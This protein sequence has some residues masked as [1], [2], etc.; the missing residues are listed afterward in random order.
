LI[1]H[2]ISTKNAFPKTNRN[3]TGKIT[4]Q[5]EVLMSYPEAIQE[6]IFTTI[7]IFYIVDCSGCKSMMKEEWKETIR[8]TEKKFVMIQQNIFS[9]LLDK[10]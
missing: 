10:R 3:S 5:H 6:Q 9:F 7:L 1:Q 4:V 8:N 2:T